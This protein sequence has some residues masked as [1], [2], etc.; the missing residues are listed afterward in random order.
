MAGRMNPN[1]EGGGPLNPGCV[2]LL[3]RALSCSVEV[4][5]HK[6][7]TFGERYLGPQAA[8]AM[9]I[10]FVFPVLSPNENPEPMM[11]FLGAFVLALAAARAGIAV[12]AKRGELGPHSMYTGTPRI[13]GRM[14]ES[15]VKRANEPI[16]VI[17][18]GA[19]VHELNAPLG[20]YLMLAGVALL[21]SAN[22]TAAG[23]RKRVLDMH[24]AFEEQRNLADRWRWMRGE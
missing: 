8:L 13:L 16:F 7:T 22:L 20:S 24:D 14:S 4:F 3:V 19:F 9:L 5:L 12:R 2:M 23:E 15:T 17:I 1:G 6:S 10:I 21:V 11:W 18:V